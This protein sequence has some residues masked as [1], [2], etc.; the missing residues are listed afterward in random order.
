[1]EPY[2][3]LHVKTHTFVLLCFQFENWLELG[4]SGVLYMGLGSLVSVSCVGSV[5]HQCNCW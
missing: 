1:M 3:F 5:K 2:W 4:L